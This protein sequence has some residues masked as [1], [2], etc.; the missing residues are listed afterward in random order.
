MVRRLGVVTAVTLA[1]ACGRLGFDPVAGDDVVGDDGPTVFTGLVLPPGGEAFDLEPVAGSAIVYAVVGGRAFRSTDGGAQWTECGAVPFALRVTADQAASNHAYLG[2]IDGAYETIDSCA[3][4]TKIFDQGEVTAIGIASDGDVLLGSNGMWRRHAGVVTPIAS[5]ADGHQVGFLAIAADTVIATTWGGGVIRS[6]DGGRT[7][8]PANIG[9]VD[10]H[11]GGI[12]FSAPGN[13]MFALLQTDDGAF[14]SSDA[15]QTWIPA[16]NGQEGRDSIACDPA[17]GSFV[18][19]STWHGMMRSTDGGV[20]FDG[21]NWRTSNMESAWISDYA[22]APGG[23]RVYAAT[24]AGLFVA[25]D[26]G[27]QWRSTHNGI[28]AWTIEELTR[29]PGQNVLLAATAAGLLRSD[30]GGASWSVH[31][32]GMEMRLSTLLTVHVPE[33]DPSRVLAGGASYLWQSTDR[34]DTFVENTAISVRE[35]D[36]WTIHVIRSRLSDIWVGTGTRLWHSEDGGSSWMAARVAVEDRIVYDLLISPAGDKWVA[37]SGGV[38]VV[39]ASEGAFSPTDTG[40]P[41]PD[42]YAVIRLDDGTILAGG[43]DGVYARPEA[44]GSTWEPAGLASEEVYELLAAGDRWI[45]ATS[46]GVRITR[47]R[48][49]TWAAIPGLATKRPSS[50]VLDA[51][52]NLVVGT[53]GYGIFRTALP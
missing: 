1:T 32:S 2:D 36:D 34:G 46:K 49:A 39:R 9:L 23:G 25:S 5:P 42:T 48:G 22:F 41:R 18:I 6:T 12:T 37:T 8:A 51:A 7:F 13:P 26:H 50:L 24:G 38:Y 15:G 17:D 29:V 20:S 11:S 44:S 16:T 35:L 30:D 21:T 53:W 14:H 52:G 43:I 4:W 10:P 31:N 19:G 45:A 3:T 28:S 27:L 47:D 33:L 40:A